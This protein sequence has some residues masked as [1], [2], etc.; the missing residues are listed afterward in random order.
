[1]SRS[2]RLIILALVG[3][4]TLSAANHPDPKAEREQAQAQQSIADSL[5]N[6]ASAYRDEAKRSQ[7]PNQET[8]PCKPGEDRR[9]SDL[10][11]Q[12]KAA[13]AAA[14][15]AW[16]AWA[17]G[18]VGIGGLVG[19]LI[20]ICLAFQANTIARNTAK[21]QLRAYVTIKEVRIVEDSGK[22]DQYCRVQVLFENTG[23]TPAT[24]ARSF[25]RAC[26]VKAEDF[27]GK[28]PNLPEPKAVTWNSV[29]I[30]GRNGISDNTAEM[31]GFSRIRAI[32]EVNSGALALVCYGYILYNDIFGDEHFTHFRYHLRKDSRLP[33]GVFEMGIDNFMSHEEIWV[34]KIKPAQQP[35]A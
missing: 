28:L 20:A 25:V 10:C 31:K 34:D 32:S 4:L 21:R 8:E 30:L 16:W 15:S 13:D 3:W 14:D 24:F 19:V 5:D 9:Y 27:N 29:F 26:A 1:M 18:L 17:A 23:E 2:Y 12:W 11:A 7:A 22:S 6:I 35:E 33:N